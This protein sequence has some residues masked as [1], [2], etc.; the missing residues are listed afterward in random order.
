VHVK[1]VSMMK[2]VVKKRRRWRPTRGFL[3]VVAV[4]FVVYWATHR[5]PAPRPVSAPGTVVHHHRSRVV[6]APPLDTWTTVDAPPVPISEPDGILVVYGQPKPL[7]EDHP[8]A[9]GP[10]GSTTKLMTAYLV[11]ASLP[12]RQVVTISDRAAGTGGSEMFMQPGNRFTVHQL[13]IGMILRSANDAAVA[14]SQAVSGHEATFVQLMNATARRLGLN[15]TAYADPDGISP[16]SESSAA[17]LARLAEIDLA[18]PVLAPI[19]VMRQTSLPENPVVINI[20]G[21][22]WRDPY[23]LGLKTGWTSESMACVVF[24]SKR[25][26]DGVPVTLVG[27]VLHG[28]SF[29]VAYQ[30]AQNLLAWGFRQMQPVVAQWRRDGRIPANLNP[31]VNVPTAGGLSP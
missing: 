24:A 13:L 11:Q 5:G 30:D 31:P 29:P 15:H 2:R 23:S 27:V 6:S 7:W 4:V 17:D 14:L 3:L 18:S 22:V 20:N 10:V 12:L 21:M 16:G 26:V 25:L 1:W 28:P 19:F 8:Y 9:E